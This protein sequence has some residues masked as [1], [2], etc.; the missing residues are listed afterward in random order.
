MSRARTHAAVAGFD[1]GADAYER[2]RPDYPDAAVAHLRDA[3]GL[4]AGARLLELGAG[5]G[6]FTRSLVEWGFPLL[7]VEPT[8]G[9]RIVFRRSLPSVPLVDATAEAIPVRSG[10]VGAVVAAQA[11]HW[12]RQPETLREIARVLVPGGGLGLVW[13]VRDE[14]V[15]WVA[16]LG[17]TFERYAEGIPRTRDGAWRAA[18]E[19]DPAFGPLDTRSFRHVQRVDVAGV[20][21]RVL[22]I[23]AVAILDDAAKRAVADEVRALLERESATRGRGIVE[24]PYRTDVFVTHRSR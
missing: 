18:V 21:D 10:S 3:L 20:V 15:P 12:F 17:R 22:S 9:M 16:A 11:F 23:S 24:I 4:R 5:T 14:S 13:N 19:E 1:R 6:K 2:G 8:R 7:A